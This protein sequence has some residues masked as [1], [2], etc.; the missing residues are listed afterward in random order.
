VEEGIDAMTF[1]DSVTSFYY[2]TY[3][4]ID[5]SDYVTP[6]LVVWTAAKFLFYVIPIL[7]LMAA[8]DKERVVNR[9]GKIPR[10]SR[11]MRTWSVWMIL[12]PLLDCFVYFYIVLSL[13]GR[14]QGLYPKTAEKC[15]VYGISAGIMNVIILY[16]VND[17]L[18]S[19]NSLVVV[20]QM[21]FLLLMI[22]SL[23]LSWALVSARHL[24]YIYKLIDEVGRKVQHPELY[25]DYDRGNKPFTA[26]HL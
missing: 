3:D 16:I 12:V 5:A 7:E 17:T 11:Y 23:T 20:S 18:T 22:I 10:L 24:F 2:G 13:I 26:E 25:S 6:I 19:H 14:V 21:E 8:Y 9:G 15:Q 4:V 1:E